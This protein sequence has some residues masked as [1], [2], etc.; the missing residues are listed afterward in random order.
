[1]LPGFFFIA[2]LYPSFPFKFS[3]LHD[4]PLVVLQYASQRIA[5]KHAISLLSLFCLYV[6]A[7]REPAVFAKPTG[8][9]SE[10][11]HEKLT[12]AQARRGTPGDPF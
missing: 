12:I 2:I 8:C 10:V 1:M 5:E 9:E 7:L 6:Q 3:L 4:D 11:P